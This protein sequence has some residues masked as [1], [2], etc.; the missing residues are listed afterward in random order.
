MLLLDEATSAL[1][2]QT[3]CAILKNIKTMTDKACI[4]VS[5]RNAVFDIC[6]CI[7]TLEDGTATVKEGKK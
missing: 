3:E 7:M 2:E 4:V 1:D 6:D 5:H